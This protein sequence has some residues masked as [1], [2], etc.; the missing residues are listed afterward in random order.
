MIR[1]YQA[2]DRKEETLEYLMASVKREAEKLGEYTLITNPLDLGKEIAP[3]GV[4]YPQT[5]AKLILLRNSVDELQNGDIFVYV[6]SDMYAKTFKGYIDYINNS[7]KYFFFTAYL[8]GMV[9]S[10][11]MALKI[12]DTTREIVKNLEMRNET[13]LRTNYLGEVQ[14]TTD[15]EIWNYNFMNNFTG[16]NQYVDF[17]PTKRFS[18]IPQ[19]RLFGNEL[20]FLEISKET[21]I[22]HFLR[23]SKEYCREILD[24]I[25]S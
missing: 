24:E 2:E 11:L 14:A 8:T 17:V 3:S 9:N 7:N 20:P 25:L 23:E 10:G 16:I 12:N 21:E 15:E 5:Y 22:F 1:F 18:S 13:Y 19:K 6:D 4:K